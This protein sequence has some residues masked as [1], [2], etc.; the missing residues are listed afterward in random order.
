[1][2]PLIDG[3]RFMSTLL[4][5]FRRAKSGDSIYSTMFEV[6]GDVMLDPLASVRNKADII[7]ITLF[8]Y[9]FS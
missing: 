5:D 9:C 1:M 3:K 6:N 2:T 7:V 4:K 8:Y